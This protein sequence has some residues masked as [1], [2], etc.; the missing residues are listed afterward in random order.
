[1]NLC[2]KLV[3]GLVVDHPVLLENLQQEY[4]NISLDN[5]PEPYVKFE[6]ISQPY[7]SPFEKNLQHSYIIVD[8]IVKDNWTWDQM[9]QEEKTEVTAKTQ[10]TD[11]WT[12]NRQT[13]QIIPPVDMPILQL[14]AMTEA[15]VKVKPNW[16]E[17]IQNW[18]LV[19]IDNPTIIY[20]IVA[21]EYT[22][23]QLTNQNKKLVW[24]KETNTLEYINN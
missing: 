19:D 12:F 6:R 3:D 22:Q 11:S 23:E 9:T 1:M 14:R 24:N 15:G 5:L 21:L 7:L 10:I 13:G 4:P 17:Q 2:I 8:G 18:Q 16:I 20:P